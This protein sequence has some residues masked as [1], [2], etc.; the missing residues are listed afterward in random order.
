MFSLPSGLNS[1]DSLRMLYSTRMADLLTRLRQEFDAVLIDT[2]PVLAVADARILS[3][4]VDVIVLVVRAGLT[5]RES[6]AAAVNVL[7]ADGVPV[8]GTVLNDWTPHAT[9]ADYA[10]GYG[11]YDPGRLESRDVA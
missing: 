1:H 5:T 4:L 2:P 3:R 11:Q 10:S 8:L 7:E 9:D 6:A